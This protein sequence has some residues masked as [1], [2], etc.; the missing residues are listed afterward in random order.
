MD[1]LQTYKEKLE[2]LDTMLKHM[3]SSQHGRLM[4]LK[5]CV[6]VLLII[7]NDETRIKN[8]YGPKTPIIHFSLQ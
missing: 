4:Q 5:R 1:P 7:L 2:K 6:S 3:N 8:P